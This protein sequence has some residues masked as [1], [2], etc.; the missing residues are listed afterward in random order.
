MPSSTSFSSAPFTAGKDKSSAVAAVRAPTVVVALIVTVVAVAA[1]VPA[2]LVA[3]SLPEAM[4]VP[5][6]VQVAV[7]E[8]SLLMARAL[9]RRRL[10]GT[11]QQAESSLLRVMW[12][13]VQVGRSGPMATRADTYAIKRSI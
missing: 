2:L 6:E 7:G 8:C 9:F 13:G 11:K 4:A 12:A 1:A 3:L 10:R 5:P